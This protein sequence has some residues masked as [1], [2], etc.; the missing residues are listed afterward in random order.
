MLVFLRYCDAD[1]WI[2][3]FILAKCDVPTITFKPKDIDVLNWNYPSF[4]FSILKDKSMFQWFTPKKIVGY[5]RL[6]SILM[7]SRILWT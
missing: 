6:S 7:S 1:V 4:E 5:G 2:A 3:L